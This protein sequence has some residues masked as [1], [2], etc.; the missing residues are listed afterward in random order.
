L[1]ARVFL[2]GMRSN[3]RPATASLAGFDEHVHQAADDLDVLRVGG[4]DE[5]VARLVGLDA[6]VVDGWPGGAE[7]LLALLHEAFEL[8]GELLGAGG[9]GQLDDV[10]RRPRDAWAWIRA[11]RRGR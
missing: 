4:D 6:D 3:K 1:A 7:R 8:V 5:R 11:W 10:Q 2:R 9:V